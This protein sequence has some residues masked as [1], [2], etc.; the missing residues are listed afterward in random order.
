MPPHNVRQA[1]DAV[2]DVVKAASP[3]KREA[4]VQ[5]IDAYVDEFPDD[6]FW[7]GSTHAAEL[8]NHILNTIDSACRPGGDDGDRRVIV[9]DGETATSN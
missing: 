8:L 1:S 2:H 9:V 7:S 5:T 4:L 6:Y 3:A